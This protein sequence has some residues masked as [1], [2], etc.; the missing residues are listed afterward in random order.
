M[1]CSALPLYTLLLPANAGF[2]ADQEVV[3][4]HKPPVVGEAM[5]FSMTRHGQWRNNYF[6]VAEI[7]GNQIR[8]ALSF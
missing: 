4:L 1:C 3:E 5:C 2:A 8:L 7:N 6:N